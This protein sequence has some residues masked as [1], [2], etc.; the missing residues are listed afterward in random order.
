MVLDSRRKIGSI[1]HAKALH[2]TNKA[3]CSRR[4]GAG[5]VNKWVEGTVVEAKEIQKAGNS[6]KSWFILAD[7]DLGGG[8]M[9][10]ADLNL[11]SVK[12]GKIPSVLAV[13]PPGPPAHPIP[14][15]AP[16]IRPPIPL[17]PPIEPAQGDQVDNNRSGLDQVEDLLQELEELL[18]PPIQ[19]VRPAQAPAQAPAQQLPTTIAHDTSWFEDQEACQLPIGGN[20]PFR[21]WSIRTNFGDSLGPGGDIR[22]SLLT[23]SC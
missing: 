14:P 10:R 20:V 22:K 13:A 3:E 21:E 18:P 8:D 19:N 17:A 2:V 9:K 1:V 6:R 16:P 15:P 7:Y 5:K 11:R 12:S 23:T 4:Y